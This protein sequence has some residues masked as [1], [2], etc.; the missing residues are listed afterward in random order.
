MKLYEK[1]EQFC[2]LFDEVSKYEGGV[3]YGELIRQVRKGLD[4]DF[5]LVHL[6]NYTQNRNPYAQALLYHNQDLFQSAY[7]FATWYE[8]L[9]DKEKQHFKDKAKKAHF[10]RMKDNV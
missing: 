2:R 3:V 9:S 4:S 10:D 5:I 6:L 8:S 7:E 1:K